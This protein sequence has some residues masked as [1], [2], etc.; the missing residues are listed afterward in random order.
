VAIESPEA[1]RHAASRSPERVEMNGNKE[2]E[3]LI[4]TLMLNL[5]D[6]TIDAC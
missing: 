1:E 6:W 2:M 5:V 4:E 3:T